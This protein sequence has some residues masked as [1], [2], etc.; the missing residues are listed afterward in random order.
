METKTNGD[1]LTGGDWLEVLR[2]IRE[3][4]E[5]KKPFGHPDAPTFTGK[6]YQANETEKHFTEIKQRELLLNMIQSSIMYTIA[7]FAA[8][9]IPQIRTTL[10]KNIRSPVPMCMLC[11]FLGLFRG[12]FKGS[13]QAAMQRFQ[14]GDSPIGR[15]SR[16]KLHQYAPNHPWLNPFQHEFQQQNFQSQESFQFAQ[17]PYQQYQQDRYEQDPYQ[18]NQQNFQQQQSDDGENI[19]LMNPYGSGHSVRTKD[20]FVVDEWFQQGHDPFAQ[21][22]RQKHVDKREEMKK[23]GGKSNWKKPNPNA[24]VTRKTVSK[25]EEA[26]GDF[27][28]FVSEED[29]QHGE[30]AFGEQQFIHPENHHPRDQW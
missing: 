8:W 5:G 19:S 30:Q 14:L 2:H 16:W 3:V 21:K 25:K 20:S 4:R 12:S 23:R 27:G 17:D 9:T 7:P 11:S 18:Q 1:K 15:E 22:V 10:L 6:P 26:R 24:D 28:D 29:F 13:E